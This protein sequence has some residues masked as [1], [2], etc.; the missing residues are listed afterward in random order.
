V[1][2]VEADEA[3]DTVVSS[4]HA[5]S[6][7]HRDS[8]A[9]VRRAPPPRSKPAQ[10]MSDQDMLKVLERFPPGPPVT[11]YHVDS[12]GGILKAVK[13]HKQN[14][15]SEL[16]SKNFWLATDVQSRTGF[17]GGKGLDNVIAFQV[18]RRCVE[19]MAE[20]AQGQERAKDIET[21]FRILFESAISEPVPMAVPMWH[22]EGGGGGSMPEPHFNIA[23]RHQPGAKQMLQ[24]FRLSILDIS[25]Y[26]LENG[27]LV[28]QERI[29]PAPQ[30]GAPPKT[31]APA[32]P[33]TA[34]EQ[35]EGRYRGLSKRQRG[36][37]KKAAALKARAQNKP[38]QPTPPEAETLTAR[39]AEKQP[40]ARPTP[41]EQTEAQQPIPKQ[42]GAKPPVGETQAGEKLAAQGTKT[43]EAAKP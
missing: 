3:A 36:E 20:L 10:G 2:E 1:A 6:I 23:I 28:L 12:E 40:A 35:E 13:E 24:L 38:P 37:A 27:K 17:K 14:F 34:A 9:V 39:S 16:T 18:D 11:L 15:T 30:G 42:G 21:L 41:G 7:S 8:G 29:Y 25:H 32:K 43:S 19:V 4:A 5:P 33:K 31:G 26:S 22:V